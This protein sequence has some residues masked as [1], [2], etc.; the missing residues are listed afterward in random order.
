MGAHHVIDMYRDVFAYVVDD[1][2]LSLAFKTSFLM[3]PGA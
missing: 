1:G 2:C 3:E